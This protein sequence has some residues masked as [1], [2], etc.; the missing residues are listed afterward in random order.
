MTV[1]KLTHNSWRGML[2]RCRNPKHIAFRLYGARGIRVCERWHKYANFLEDMGKRP[3]K[4]HQIDRIDGDKDY[5]KSN[6][7]WVTRSENCV[8]RRHVG[9]YRGVEID[10]VRKTI[11]QWSAESPV[12]DVAIA[13]RLRL[14]W[15]PRDAVFTEPTIYRKVGVNDRYIMREL[16]ENGITPAE[17]G[18][19]FAVDPSTAWRIVHTKG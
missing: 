5:E 17:L 7:R 13:R 3:S 1:D 11:T 15:S 14:G 16:Y 10:G 8:N 18:R 19:R 4:K 2:D 12:S 6:C 9:R